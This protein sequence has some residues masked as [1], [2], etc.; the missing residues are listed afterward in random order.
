MLWSHRRQFILCIIRKEGF[1]PLK[2]D[3]RKA[4]D[5]VNWDFLHLTF[6]QFGLPSSTINLI[7]N[8]T[9]STSLSLKWNN[10]V[11]HN[12]SPTRGL[13]QGDPMS[14]YL[15]VLC[16]EKLALLIQQ[17]A[18]KG[19]WKPV[20]IFK[21]GPAFSHLFFLLMTVSC[22]LKLDRIRFV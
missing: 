10:E 18:D 8:C 20:W 22:S 6:A 16:M 2:V 11:C 13:R 19:D 12:F 5:K 1:I 3:F 9:T 7:M 21:N 17:S 4:Y 15:F 14:P